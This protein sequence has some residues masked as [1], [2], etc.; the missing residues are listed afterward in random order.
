[1]NKGSVLVV[2]HEPTPYIMGLLERLGKIW[3][4][5]FEVIFTGVNLSQSW[6]ISPEGANMQVL[7]RAPLAALALLARRID[8]AGLV[9]LAGWSGHPVM[10]TAL[11]LAFVKRVPVTIESDTPPPFHT[12]LWKQLLKQLCY[13]LI[14]RIPVMFFPAGTRQAQYLRQY[15]VPPAR[16][17]IAQMTV[18]VT[19]I[20]RHV[21]AV[22]DA[23]R[24]ALRQGFGCGTGDCVF[25]FVG[26]LEPSKGI[27]ELIAAF[28]MLAKGNVQPRLVIVGDGSLADTVRTAAAADPAITATGRL[29]GND[30]L[31]A[32]AAADVFVL[33]SLFEPWGLVV[34]EAMAAGLPVIASAR[35]G[36]TD[37][38][39]KE[40]QTG[41][42]VPAGDVAALA[43]IMQTLLDNPQTR[44]ALGDNARSLIAGWTL[45]H[46]AAIVADAWKTLVTV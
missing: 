43:S 6:E 16:I 10:L 14:F 20:T 44:Q 36:C 38:L 25:L 46:E 3:P 19:R 13:P 24:T 41:H 45:E 21:Q 29:A 7:P 15:G 17:T 4:Q 34:N 33:P 37:D 30:L 40:G 35:A 27:A 5:G 23:A 39:V 11:A 8:Q 28:A 2:Y 12:R 31:N 42:T 18:D 9:H 1:M 26:R 22:P 32:Y